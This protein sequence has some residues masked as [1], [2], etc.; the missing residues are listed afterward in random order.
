MRHR[1][2]ASL[3][4]ILAIERTAA[5]CATCSCGDATLVSM[6]AEQPFDERLRTSLDLRTRSE[7]SGIPGRDQIDVRE[8]RSEL[9]AAYSP[10]DRLTLSLGV[11]LVQRTLQTVSL[12]EERGRGLGDVE[13]RARATLLRDRSL[14]P[15]HLVTV[16]LGVT[17]PT[18]QRLGGP[19]DVPLSDD[20]QPGAQVLALAP[21]LAYAHFAQPWSA[22]LSATWLAPVW[23]R[24]ALR[25]G[26]SL[27]T[28]A[29]I[30]LQPW[31]ALAMRGGVDTRWES[32]ATVAE[33]PLPYS[34]GWMAAM[35]VDALV[36][37]VEDVIVQA[38]AKLP[39]RESTPDR[40]EGMTLSLSVIFDV[41][42]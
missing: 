35:S 17:T 34:G 23:G 25:P 19:G 40:R 12:A 39:F 41:T 18:A 28:T 42:L 6:G 16:G 29:A 4:A 14:A 8:W 36:S 2:W 33:R 20:A 5:A 21:S 3:L 30:Q 24:T 11:P 37:P 27:R 22:Y 32:A 13:L 38:G 31:S 10:A 15:R 9:S 7:R 26:S 1:L